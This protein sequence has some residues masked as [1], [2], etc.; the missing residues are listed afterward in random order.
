MAVILP[1]YGFLAAT[2]PVWLLLAPR[3]Y[4][5][6][7]IKIGVFVMLAVG[8]LIINPTIKMPFTTHF[9]SC[10]GPVLPGPVWPY[11]FITIACGA[12]SGF[13]ALIGTGTTPK[14]V[15]KETHI[16]T[17]GYGAMLAEAF[18]AVMALLAAVMFHPADYFAINTS[19]DVF[20]KLGMSVVDLPVLSKLVGLDITG[21]PGGIISLAVGMSNVFSS[22]AEGLRHIMKYWFQFVIVFEALFILTVIDAGTRV[23]RYIL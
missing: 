4:L 2:L 18:V 17:I 16:R 7:Y 8:L 21:R 22:V 10:G 12:I 13:H 19:P 15:E 11:V 3:D 5:S 1:T 20:A 6:T 23:A 14:L 9:I